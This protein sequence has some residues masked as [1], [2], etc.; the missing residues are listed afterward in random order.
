MVAASKQSSAR[1]FEHCQA[2]ARP[3]AELIPAPGCGAPVGR[4]SVDARRAASSASGVPG[5]TQRLGSAMCTHSRTPPPGSSSAASPS[6]ISAARRRALGSPPRPHG[7]A[8]LHRLRGSRACPAYCQVN[9][10]QLISICWSP[11][12]PHRRTRRLPA[13]GRAEGR[14]QSRAIAPLPRARSSSANNP[15]PNYSLIPIIRARRRRGAR[16]ACSGR[17]W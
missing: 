5:C 15:N 17:R 10:V 6:S 2:R 13:A 3:V 8:M 16:P 4:Y 11:A 14:R 12:P 9:D 1:A 7:P